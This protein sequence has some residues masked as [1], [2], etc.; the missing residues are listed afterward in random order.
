MDAGEVI[1]NYIGTVEALRRKG[2]DVSVRDKDGRVEASR[3]LEIDHQMLSRLI[4]DGTIHVIES[5]GD[6]WVCKESLF[7][8]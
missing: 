7:L 2:A 3:V 5:S 1:A 8:N 4:V 6:I